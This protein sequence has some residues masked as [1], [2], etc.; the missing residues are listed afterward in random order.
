MT[1]IP[2]TATN[3]IRVARARVAGRAIEVVEARAVRWLFDRDRRRFLRLPRDANLDVGVLALDWQ[4]YADVTID[5]DG[6]G[7]VVT[8]DDEGLV[9]LHAIPEA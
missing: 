5:A 1:A 6:S 2:E 3:A 4:P 7:V 8:L 9:R